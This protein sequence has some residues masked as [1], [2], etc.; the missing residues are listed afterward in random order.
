MYLVFSWFTSQTL[1][2][3]GRA[4]FCRTWLEGTCY[5]LVKGFC[6]TLSGAG[7]KPTSLS[8]DFCP[9]TEFF[10]PISSDEKGTTS[11]A[12]ALANHLATS[13][14]S[15][16]FGHATQWPTFFFRPPNYGV[17]VVW[18]LFLNASAFS[19]WAVCSNTWWGRGIKSY[20]APL[21]GIPCDSSFNS[22]YELIFKYTSD[23]ILLAK[24]KGYLIHL[25]P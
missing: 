16:S 22:V 19:C 25:R 12:K 21:R 14:S 11:G 5:L 7:W 6:S 13:S 9:Q 24:F 8:A 18:P 15:T 4:A 3:Y 10:I 2:F 23:N 17:Q 1:I 20:F